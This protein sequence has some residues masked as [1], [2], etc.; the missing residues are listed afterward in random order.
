M[1]LSTFSAAYKL[2]AASA[3][4]PFARH[5]LG[6]LLRHMRRLHPSSGASG[7]HFAGLGAG[8]GAFARTLTST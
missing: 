1:P 6:I 2:P 4:D 7:R 3:N 8:L 5:V